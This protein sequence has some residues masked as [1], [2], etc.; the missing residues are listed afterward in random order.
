[1]QCVPSVIPCLN[2]YTM[3]M[4]M[5]P[6]LHALQMYYLVAITKHVT[7]LRGFHEIAVLS[8]PPKHFLRSYVTVCV[9]RLQWRIWLNLMLLQI[10]PFLFF[11]S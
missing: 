8:F 7:I 9:V 11:S 1:M 4:N 5:C 6:Q 2:H 3:P 10:V